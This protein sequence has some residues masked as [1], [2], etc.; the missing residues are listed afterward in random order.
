VRRASAILILSLVASAWVTALLAAP[1]AGSRSTVLASGL[2]YTA[3]SLICHQDPERSFYLNGAQLPVCARC[4]G[5]Y[6]G[7]AL[8]VVAWVGIAGM[9]RRPSLRAQRVASSP[10][11][12]RAIV[13][14][15]LPT[16]LSVV[17]A[18]LGWSDLQN[19]A[20]AMLALP[21]GAVVGAVVCAVAAGDLR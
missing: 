6:V 15:A 20:R 2:I 18:W 21:L 10:Q 3:G 19:N 16:V 12:R 14:I 1:F 8:G 4:L 9:R 13:L 17:V 11:L 5:L 7:G